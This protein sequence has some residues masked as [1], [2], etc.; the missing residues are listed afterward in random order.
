MKIDNYTKFI[1]T[2]IAFCLVVLTLN[3]V[4]IFPKAYANE[5]APFPQQNYAIVPLNEDGSISVSLVGLDEIDVDITGIS[6]S[7]ELDINIDEVA[8]RSPNQGIPVRKY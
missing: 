7:D 4:D 2:I 8:G 3:N 5:P 6:T 1:L